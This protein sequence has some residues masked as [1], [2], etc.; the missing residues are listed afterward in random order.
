LLIGIAL[1]DLGEWLPRILFAQL[2]VV[3][4]ITWALRQGMVESQVWKDAQQEAGH[5]AGAFKELFKHTR[6]LAFLIVMYGVWNLVAG[7]YGFFFPSTSSRPSA[8]PPIARTTRCRRSGSCPPRSPS[9]R[10]TCR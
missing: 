8:T 9:A 3:A 6:A 10:S 5:A 1:L 7:T 4:M 2:F